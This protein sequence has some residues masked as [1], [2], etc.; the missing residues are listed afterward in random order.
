[1][2][3]VGFIG[4][5]RI[6]DLH[7]PGYKNN[8]EARIYAVC[9]SDPETARL[10]Q[11]QWKA[12]KAYTDYRELLADPKIQAVEILTP[13]SFHEPMVLDAAAAGKHIA[14]QKPM[15]TSL[16]SAD[17]MI[18]A[19]RRANVVFRVTDNYVWYPPTVMAKKMI[20]NGEIGTPMNLKI[21]LIVGGSGGWAVP[22]SS[23][24]WRM[25]DFEKGFPEEAFDHG[26]HLWST[27]WFLFGPMERVVSWIDSADGIVDTP[28]VA[29][30]KHREGMR[31]GMCEIV[32]ANQMHVPSKYYANDEWMEIT[33][34][35]G[36]IVINRCNGNIKGGPP[37]SLFNGK[38][39]QHYPSVKCDW[40]E[41]FIGATRNFIGAI[42][43]GESPRLSGEDGREILRFA[44]ALLRSNRIRREVYLDEMDSSFPGILYRRRVAKDKKARRHKKSLLER[45]GIGGSAA[46]L[47]PKARELTEALAARFNPEAVKGWECLIGLHLLAEG[48]VQEI[49]YSI[50]VKK[51]TMTMTEGAVPEGAVFTLK[52]G[53]GTWAAILMKK[54]RLETAFIT[55]KL[56]VEGKAEEALKLRSAVGL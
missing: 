11:K 15:T 28:S 42:R 20:D 45:L 4:C 52:V 26:H 2:I 44:L 30:W 18:D 12:D 32:C 41:G 6:S 56:K 13:H 31:Y 21:K 54:K 55:G 10:R 22:A 23:W 39:W 37:V 1:M 16:E 25:K 49:K 7:F 50:Q 33:G 46:R 48:G 38:K 9:D 27:A 14:L 8:R 36:I 17:R 19:A 43:K 35:H 3:N 29:M 51:G 5:G 40:S 24:E 34:T 53:S 47:A